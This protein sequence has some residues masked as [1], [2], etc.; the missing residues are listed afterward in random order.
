M[1]MPTHYLFRYTNSYGEKFYFV[2]LG[3]EWKERPGFFPVSATTPHMDRA[4][5]F[6]CL[7]DA[8]EVWVKS[9]R[10]PGWVA[11][12]VTEGGVREVEL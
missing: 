6:E 1:T 12:E 2:S 3:E 4:C 5:K 10:V 9:N 11:L 7:K 8:L